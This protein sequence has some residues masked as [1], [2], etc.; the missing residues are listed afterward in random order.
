MGRGAASSL[1]P[2]TV[3][4]GL[5]NLLRGDDGLGVRAVQALADRDLPSDVEVIDGGT[6]GF[7]L[8]GLL[9]GR[10]RV[11]F[12]DAAQI[13][14][15]PGQF[16]RFGPDEARLLGSERQLSV[17]EAGLSEVLALAQ[18]LDALPEEVI[19]FGM[20]PAG[21]EWDDVLSP[22]V[23]AALPSLVDAVL[24]DAGNG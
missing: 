19:V 16:V 12:V 7:G 4:I 13:G 17:H 21:L 11:I 10:R 1:P 8:I 18:A 3:I 15:S 9:E 24:A 5:G 20:Q 6:H 14:R 2:A 22:E 23:E